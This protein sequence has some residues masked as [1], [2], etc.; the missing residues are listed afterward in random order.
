[1]EPPAPGRRVRGLGQQGQ[2]YSCDRR[3][4]NADQSA[5]S[6]GDEFA[7]KTIR[8]VGATP[9]GSTPRLIACCSANAIRPLR[10]RSKQR[11]ETKCEVAKPGK[12]ERTCEETNQIEHLGVQKGLEDGSELGCIASTFTCLHRLAN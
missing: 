8:K 2:Q 12:A 9:R 7:L 1:M 4:S 11:G 3:H 5:E 6:I 10:S